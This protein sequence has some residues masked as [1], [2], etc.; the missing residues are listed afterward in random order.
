MRL[1]QLIDQQQAQ[2]RFLGDTGLLVTFGAAQDQSNSP[3][4]RSLCN[5][6]ANKIKALL[7]KAYRD[8]CFGLRSVALYFDPMLMDESDQDLIAR[9]RALQLEGS[10][11]A[12]DSQQAPKKHL[13]PLCYEEGLDFQALQQEFNLSKSA[14]IDLHSACLFDV[15]LLGFLPG[16]AYMYGLNPALSC[17]RLS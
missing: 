5:K 2:I 12:Q 1:G 17:S 4:A 9:L 15:A 3:D 10:D 11:N 6:L 7:G 16:L 13:I 14:L 8:H